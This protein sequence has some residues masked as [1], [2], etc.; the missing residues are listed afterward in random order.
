MSEV[1]DFVRVESRDL[2]WVFDNFKASVLYVDNSFQR[3]FIWL[4]K[5]QISLI[6]TILKGMPMPEIY[7]WEQER[8]PASGA[9]KI[10]IIDGQQ[11]ITS[12]CKFINNEYRLEGNHLENSKSSYADKFFSELSNDD[13]TKIWGYSLSIRFVK[14]KITKEDIVKMFLRLNNT[15]MSL[16][17]QE[18]RNAEFQGKFIKLADKLS[19]LPFWSKYSIFSINQVRRMIDIQFISS[20]LIFIRKGIEEETTQENINAIYD[21][22]NEVY[23]KE[24]E[25]KVLFERLI[26]EVE[27]IIN[28]DDMIVSFLRRLTHLY[29][30]ILLIYYL[31]AKKIVIDS[32]II[33]KYKK[34][35]EAYK[36]DTNLLVVELFGESF[37]DDVINY[38]E[39]SRK[40]TQ[41]KQNRIDRLNILKRMIR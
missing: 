20:I 26:S 17:P 23:E 40:N 38:R 12:I 22:F 18:L 8:D 37:K 31:L 13:K 29:S 11:R 4:K 5:H 6:E 39:L 1:I 19:E 33:D 30:L 3:R 35:V 9:T 24:E 25:D 32:N 7:L 14:E 2:K 34:F 15:S 41:G 27:K 16:N 28:N 10:S 36:D 21:L